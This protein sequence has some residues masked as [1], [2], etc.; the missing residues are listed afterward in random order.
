MGS[1]AAMSARHVQPPSQA[2]EGGSL[3]GSMAEPKTHLPC[4]LP[5]LQ[6]PEGLMRMEREKS[7]LLL[8]LD[9]ELGV[10]VGRE[11]CPWMKFF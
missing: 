10:R 8:S 1:K 3:P 6:F 11:G 9:R 2:G 5:F 7:R 4:L